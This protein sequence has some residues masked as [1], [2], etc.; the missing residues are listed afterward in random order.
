MRALFF[1]CPWII[2]LPPAERPAA[3]AQGIFGGRLS[4]YDAAARRPMMDWEDIR[5]LAAAGHEI[6][7]HSMSHRRLVGLSPADMQREIGGSC[8]RLAEILGRR[9]SW[10]AWPFGDIMS[11]DANALSVVGR[12][13]QFCRSGVRGLNLP[14]QHRL[15]V[16]ADHIDLESSASWQKLTILGG[17]DGR[18]RA[19]RSRLFTLARATDQPQFP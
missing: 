19:A 1:V 14:G 17:L 6:G 2:D 16:F 13:V 10:F 11:I 7:A 9:P 18:Y 8:Q 3:V 12:H 5:A 4:M 15:V